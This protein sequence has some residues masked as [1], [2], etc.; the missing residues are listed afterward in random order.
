VLK[1]IGALNMKF[2]F[3]SWGI[4]IRVETSTPF[5]FAGESGS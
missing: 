2:N 5:I 4:G 3:R 1:K